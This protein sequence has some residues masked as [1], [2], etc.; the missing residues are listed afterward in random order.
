[1]AKAGFPIGKNQL[2]DSVR[3]LMVELKRP[4]PFTDNRPGKS[5]YISFL[6]RNSQICTRIPQNLTISRSTVTTAKLRE[7]ATEVH[8]Y[9]K[10]QKFDD[11]LTKPERV[12]NADEAAFFMNPKEDKVLA[13]KGEKNIY[14]LI[15]SDEKECLTVLVTGNAAGLT[16][17]TMVVFCYERIPRDI[18]HSIPSDWGIGKSESG[19]MT[20]ET[21]Y[22]YLANNPNIVKCP[23]NEPAQKPITDEQ[24]LKEL[25][26]GIR[27]FEKYVDNE[28][29]MNFKKY[30][31]WEGDPCDLSLFNFY[32]NILMKY[33]KLNEEKQGN[34]GSEGSDKTDNQVEPG[35]LNENIDNNKNDTEKENVS[36]MGEKTPE[37]IAKALDTEKSPVASTS[38]TLRIGENDQLIP[39]PFKRALFWPQPRQNKNKRKKK[40][41]VPSL[42]VSKSWQEYH[43]KKETL[44]K[45]KEDNKKK[46]GPKKKNDSSDSDTSEDDWEKSGDSLDDVSLNLYKDPQISDTE[47]DSFEDELPISKLIQK[48]KEQYKVG[49]FV[50]VLFPGKK[51][52]HKY[53]CVI[54]TVLPNE[55]VEVV[56]MKKQS[57]FDA[58]TFLLNETDNLTALR[59]SVTKSQL[60]IWFSEVYKYLKIEKYDHILEYLSRVFNDDEAAFFLNPKGDKVLAHKNDKNIYQK[61]NADE[62]ECLTVLM[63][64]NATGIVAPPMIIFKYERIPRDL[65]LSMPSSWGIGKSESGWMTGETFFEY[66]TNVFHP[67]LIEQN[68]EVPIIL[69]ID[70]H[71]SHLTLH[72]SKFCEQNGIILVALYPNATHKIQPM[73][74]A[75]FR[76]FKARWK[77]GVHQ[78]RLENINQPILKKIYFSPLLAKVIQKRIIPEVLINGFR[79]CGLVPWNPD[80]VKFGSVN[81]DKRKEKFTEEMKRLK[82]LQDGILLLDRNIDPR[83][84]SQFKETDEWTGEMQDESLFKFYKKCYNEIIKLKENLDSEN[85]KEGN[86]EDKRHEDDIQQTNNFSNSPVRAQSQNTEEENRND[87]TNDDIETNENSEHQQVHVQEITLAN[88]EN[89]VDQQTPCKKTLKMLFKTTV[90]D[91]KHIVQKLEESE[92]GDLSEASIAADTNSVTVSDQG[93]LDGKENE[94]T[95]PPTKVKRL[96][97]STISIE[98]VNKSALECFNSRKHTKATTAEESPDLQFL[99]SLLPDMAE[100][101]PNQK[102]RFKI[103]ILKLQQEILDEPRSGTLST[104]FS[105]S[106]GTQEFYTNVPT[107]TDI[108]YTDI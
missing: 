107:Y 32:K 22:E 70:G 61:V 33:T 100:M 3:H 7:W 88:P 66:V 4:N 67:W 39:S 50:L 69:F 5:W 108:R 43:E 35:V 26:N 12:F 30:E 89:T 91:L 6:K 18:A 11:I 65:A 51:R 10:T 74:V 76:T 24:S 36:P 78:W 57:P 82:E 40:E 47:A 44:K 97:K 34:G 79:K 68:I 17:P 54:Q 95:G 1:M 77:E 8:D 49:D 23:I 93:T 27:F 73:D 96:A 41:K 87:R 81:D 102:R 75:V 15:N 85:A 94:I 14:Q 52:E 84:L 20:G 106:T 21:F 92:E 64:G 9:L 86:G 99:K 59:A 48:K 28:K 13:K 103:G 71:V 105:T 46:R 72:T 98:D 31:H 42:V 29:L 55:E 37:P 2:L 25:E 38:T 90:T 16:A 45:E 56:G 63:T 62:K 19:W 83:K 80:A 58:K 101:N 104:N 53:L 60:N